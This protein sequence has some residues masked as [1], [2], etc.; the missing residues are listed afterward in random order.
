MRQAMLAGEPVPEAVASAVEQVR[1]L[2]TLPY[3][4]TLEALTALATEHA[5]LWESKIGLVYGGATKIKQYVFEASKLQDIRG[6]SALLDRINLVDLP[7][8]FADDEA[9][10]QLWLTENFPAQDGNLGLAQALIPELIVYS[11]GGNILAFCP[12]AYVDDLAN[13][14]EKRYTAE[15]LTANS[16]AVGDSFRFLELRFGLLKDDISQTPWLEWYRQNP[17]HPLVTASFGQ[18]G[19]DLT[20]QFKERKSFNE[21]VR[22]LA[23]RFNQRRSGDDRFATERPSRRYPPMFETHPY[24]R[25]DGPERRLAVSQAKQL[26]G[27]PRFSDATARKRIVGQKV[28]RETQRT[29]WFTQEQF[30]WQ[31]GRLESWTR[32]F[33]DF[34]TEQGQWPQYDPDHCRPEEARSLREIGNA[35]QGFVAYIYA[36]GNNM[37]GYIQTITTA[38]EYQ[39]FSAVVSV[40][41]EHAVYQALKTHLHPHQLHGITD[42][43]SADRNGVWVHPFEILTIGGDDVMLVVPAN[44]ALAIAQTLS[45]QF[46]VL[47][48][49]Q[50]PAFGLTQT[51]S[52]EALSA[53]HR[54]R[55]TTAKPA[56]CQLSMSAGVL[57]TAENTPIYYA[58]NLTNQ[59]LKSAKKQAKHLKKEYGYQGGTIDFLVMKAVTMLSSTVSRFREDGLIFG[60]QPH[61]KLYGAPYTLHEIGGLLETAQA[62]K[63]ANFPRSQ[64]YQIRTLLERGKRTAMLNY[65]YFWSRLNNKEAKAKL[66]AEFEDAWCQAKT[67]DG[68][69]VPWIYVEPTEAERQDPEYVPTYETIWRELVDLYPFI[70][71]PQLASAGLTATHQ[72]VQ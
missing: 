22:R 42:P 21:L 70:D 20:T 19:A 43:E 16:C 30:G 9:P 40:A 24:G 29:G 68:N 39:Q 25:R 33:E 10:S 65:R 35:S 69:L 47:L 4:E 27:E 67:N 51:P 34:L 46:E 64:L 48:V 71:E 38:E 60:T 8:F 54:Y 26:P 52:Q 2:D 17:A 14:I 18:V 58:E 49:E 66:K 5:A 28:K 55:P 7:G 61:L 44:Q 72:E 37:G 6:A 59:L 50:N 36:D 62:L 56:I 3:P 45:E 13:A 41:T 12:V 11:T 1:D 57:V 63:Q 32:R 15:T 53:I 31:P 23:V